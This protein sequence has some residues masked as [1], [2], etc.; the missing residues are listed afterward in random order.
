MTNAEFMAENDNYRYALER[1]RECYEDGIIAENSDGDYYLTYGYLTPTRKLFTK[2]DNC[3]KAYDT[4]GQL[5]VIKCGWDDFDSC[6]KEFQQWMKFP[7][8]ETNKDFLNSPWYEDFLCRILVAEDGHTGG[9]FPPDGGE[10]LYVVFDKEKDRFNIPEVQKESI[11]RTRKWLYEAVDD[12]CTRKE[13]L[14]R[15][16]NLRHLSILLIDVNYI[17][18]QY[19]HVFQK[20]IGRV[21]PLC[22]SGFETC[23]KD[24]M[25]FLNSA[26][27]YHLMHLVATERMSLMIPYRDKIRKTTYDTHDK[28]MEELEK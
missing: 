26:V 16:E 11:E 20:C 15:E 6:V 17:T 12:G 24:T 4:F 23:I 8:I 7:I 13:W 19:C 9:Y 1:A 21:Y 10:P 5:T 14:M 27:D 25:E 2:D 3:C 18:G 28:I 22:H